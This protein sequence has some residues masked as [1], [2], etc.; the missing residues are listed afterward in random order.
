M[1]IEANDGQMH[2]SEYYSD[3][4]WYFKNIVVK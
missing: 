1:G 3:V 4:N 2:T